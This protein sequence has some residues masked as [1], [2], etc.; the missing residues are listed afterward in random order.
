[1]RLEVARIDGEHRHR[2]RLLAVGQRPPV[3]GQPPREAALHR[4]VAGDA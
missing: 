3:D 1:M 4:R 2:R